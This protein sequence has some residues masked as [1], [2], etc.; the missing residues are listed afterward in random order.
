[1]KS[2][3]LNVQYGT[4]LYDGGLL[5][6]KR[7]T[8]EDAGQ[9]AIRMAGMSIEDALDSLEDALT[10]ETKVMVITIVAIRD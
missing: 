10:T 8:F 5:H 9:S 4:H 2:L 1:M 3:V 7:E 6:L